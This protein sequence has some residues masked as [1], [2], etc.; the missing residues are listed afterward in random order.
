MGIM[1]GTAAV[2]AGKHYKELQES[3]LLKGDPNRDLKLQY[4][5]GNTEGAV[6]HAVSG[7]VMDMEGDVTMGGS[8]GGEF[9]TNI[10]KTPLGKVETLKKIT[11]G[12]L[13]DSFHLT[14]E[15]YQNRLKELA[16][17]SRRKKDVR[18]DN[19]WQRCWR[20]NP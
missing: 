17:D 1:R 19:A 20:R 15:V 10:K 9:G 11:V 7:G 4:I 8:F 2:D 18:N 14:D 12:Q 16:E 5:V 6:H 3:D 13:L